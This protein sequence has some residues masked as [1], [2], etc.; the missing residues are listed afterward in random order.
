ME[1][2]K[3]NKSFRWLH[4]SDIHVGQDGQTRLWP[5]AS[6]ILLDDLETAHKKTGGFDCLV[7]SGDLVQRGSEREFDEF[8]KVLSDILN[9]LSDLGE[10]PPVITVPGNHDLIRPDRINPCAVALTRF[11]NEAELR[12]GM[13]E[14]G[15]NYL[16]FFAE[17]F[18]SYLNWQSHAIAKGIH[19]APEGLGPLAGDASYL[20][21]TAAGR[22]GVIGLNSTW[23][24]L[25][26]GDYNGEL[27][28]DAR[29]LLAITKQA[30]DEWVR[31]NDINLLV[32]HQPATWLHRDSPASWDADLNPAGRFDLHLFG[33]MH[34]PDVTTI[35][36][37]GGPARRS[38]Q[39]ASLFGLEKYG[40]GHIRIQGYSAN[41]IALRGAEREF[42]NWPRRLVSVAGG[43]M[44]LAPDLS[45]EIDENTGALTILYNVERR[46]T[47]R[48]KEASSPLRVDSDGAAS[49][50]VSTRFDL[51]AIRH[52]VAELKGHLKVRRM[53][54]DACVAALSGGRVA[55]LVSDWGMGEE[56]FVS[57][58]CVRLGLSR[59]NVFNVD[60][61]DY[62]PTDVLFDGLHTRLGGT[63]QEMCDA[64]AEAGPCVLVLDD[65]DVKS[66]GTLEKSLET[67]VGP[68]TDFA[69]NAHI[70]IRS[71]RRPKGISVPIIELK[72]LEEPD[73]AIYVRES[74]RGE[75]RFAKPD[76]VSKLFRHTDGV[77]SR[78]DDALRDLEIISLSDLISANPD[79]G[80]FALAPTTPAALVATVAE[81]ARSDD[82]AEERAYN[83]LLALSGLPQGEQLARL[84]RFLGPH[85]FYA[86]HAR[87]LVER[88]L[89]DTVTIT[90]LEGL[91]GDDTLKALIVP[92]PVREYVRSVMA[93]STVKSFDRKALD[94]YF[95]DNWVSGKIGSSPTGR[96]VR[97]ALCHGYEINNA[98]AL[99][100][101]STRRS[102]VEESE[103]ETGQLI[104]LAKAFIE[105]LI[106]GDHFRAAAS[107]SEDS[108][109]LLEEFETSSEEINFL[110]YDLARSLRMIGRPNEARNE[111]ER[112]DLKALPKSQRQ[113]AEL[114]LAL[115]L[116]RLKDAGA[117]AEAAKRVIAIDKSSSSALQARVIIAKQIEDAPKRKGELQRLLAIAIKD[118]HTVTANNIRL[119]MA[120]E[121]ED[122][123]KAS[124]LLKGV[125][126][127]SGSHDFYNSVRAAVE[128][129]ERGS[130]SSD[131]TGTERSRLVDAYHFLY[132]ERLVS[133]F[134]RCHDVLWSDFE[135]SGQIS[136]LLNLFRHSSFIWRLNGRE[137]TEARYLAKLARMARD[138]ILSNDTLNS[139]DGAYFVV[140]VSLVMK[141]LGKPLTQP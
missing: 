18:K 46:V 50:L 13:W 51:T 12:N 138:I 44:K 16:T 113:S 102:L 134:D 26:G 34:E 99:I 76:A 53:E 1:V 32:T 81:L 64:L 2:I 36:H 104:R 82:R 40:E 17:V 47:A 110:R 141:D 105:T 6:T 94:L 57:S 96:R 3:D 33:H 5:R 78:L 55:W 72:A 31:A 42:T 111:F 126:A 93:E 56:G 116:E 43:R 62:D 45:Q 107:L 14:S 77:P 61:N 109:R 84:T 106:V 114:G 29:Q 52:P 127:P 71:R 4:F 23:L 11:W 66:S 74:E 129:A 54:Q 91:P 86:S 21:N 19:L 39:A 60:F 38:I 59:D 83:L 35:A 73:V 22:V 85:P 67:L 63:F 128:L 123:E 80:D 135:R 115:T 136:N 119:A 58:I 20:L 137:S 132:S 30:P 10:R 37:G 70:I 108:I 49:K 24:Q 48:P 131:L 124:I 69:N 88:S 65:I 120:A 25:G 133:L 90:T 89:V 117:A 79:Y 41:Q 112:L 75:D 122:D 130:R 98:A 103:T 101:R 15:S 95:G 140:R 92:R 28:V 118:G 27:H 68:V 139:R 9:R 8:D 7:F 121:E 87:A 97:S 125:Q 100:L